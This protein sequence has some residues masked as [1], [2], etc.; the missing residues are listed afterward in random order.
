MGAPGPESQRSAAPERCAGGG[1]GVSAAAS[2]EAL[3]DSPDSGGRAGDRTRLRFP[4][5]VGY[6]RPRV[7]G[8][9]AGPCPEAVGAVVGAR[10]PS[11]SHPA[12]GLE[13]GSG[14]AS[15]GRLRCLAAVSDPL[16]VGVTPSR[17]LLFWV[18]GR[19]GKG[20]ASCPFLGAGRLDGTAGPPLERWPF[21]L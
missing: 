8:A 9:G 5:S 13:V 20:V 14:R 10:F 11:P 1:D 12:P 4:V 2:P 21:H 7:S 18:P 17:E 3:G 6:F 15:W 19:G 16:T